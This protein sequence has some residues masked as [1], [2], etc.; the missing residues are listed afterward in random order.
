M[1]TD[2]HA[3]WQASKDGRW[4]DIESKWE[5]D[6]HY[7]LFSWLANVRNGFGLAGVPTY[8]PV[9]P[10]AEPRGLP[11]DFDH[12]EEDHPTIL[13]A[14][15]LRSRE[16]MEE[17]EKARPM[18]WMGDHT[19]S[20]LSADEILSAPRPGALKRTGI[21]TRKQYED[22]DGV[23]PF[24]HWFGGII[25]ASIIVANSKDDITV[26]GTKF[27]IAAWV[28]EGAKGKFFSLAVT[29]KDADRDD[30]RPSRNE[31]DESSDIPF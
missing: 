31:P 8:D 30:K 10:I 16:W 15:D 1:G 17:E 4:V 9:R 25:G 29:P 2:V 3:V 28:K 20:W 5:Q 24:E 6:R 13:E 23:T 7:L 27:W 19:H 22:W 14:I 12:D 26:D 18:I 21:V 11:D